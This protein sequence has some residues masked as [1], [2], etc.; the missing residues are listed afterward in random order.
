MPVSSLKGS[1]K[2]NQAVHDALFPGGKRMRPL[3]TL[4]AT[5]TAAGSWRNALLAACAV[6]YL[7]TCSLILEFARHI[8]QP[9]IDRARECLGS[10]ATEIRES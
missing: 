5:H 10:E 9:V 7:H 3:L 6:E 1:E 2:L 4:L 8:S